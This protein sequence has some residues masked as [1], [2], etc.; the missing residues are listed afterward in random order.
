MSVAVPVIDY[1]D[2]VARRIYLLAGIDAY[3]PL[4]D[5]YAEVRNLR[6]TD[7]SLQSY[8]VFVQGGGNIPKDV[9]GTLRTPRYAI[10]QNCQVVVSGDTQVTGEQ[11]FADANGDVI[12]KGPDCI[13]HALSP[14]DAYVDY[15]PPGAEVIVI[16]TGTSGLTA[17][18]SSQ[19]STI[20][21]NNELARKLMNNRQELQLVG[22][23]WHM[24]TYDDDGVTLLFDS[25][26]KDKDG[27]D[28]SLASG[29]IAKRAAG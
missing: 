24:M 8:L 10:F 23:V 3:H 14:L 1:I 15:T 28:V 5:I 9:T 27:A 17:G 4:D 25:V 21:T 26:L 7:E 13:D 20:Y 19:L 12:G 18:E 29:A 16:E 11:L 22:D 6:R 2:P